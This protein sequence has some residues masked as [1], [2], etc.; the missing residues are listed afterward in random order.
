MTQRKLLFPDAAGGSGDDKGNFFE[1]WEEAWR[2]QTM[3]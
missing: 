3:L 1:A 2:Q